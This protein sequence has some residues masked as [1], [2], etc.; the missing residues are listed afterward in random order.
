MIGQA[1]AQYKA[2]LSVDDEQDQTARAQQLAKLAEI[3]QDF[4]SR[5]IPGDAVGNA[6]K[7]FQHLVAA[8]T[9][10]SALDAIGEDG[11]YLARA[12]LALDTL[13]AAVTS[14]VAGGDVSSMAFRSIG[15]TVTVPTVSSIG[16]ALPGL[17]AGTHPHEPY[18]QFRN[19][20]GQPMRERNPRVYALLLQAQARLLQIWNGFNYLGYRDDYVPPW[21]FQYLL[22]RARYFSEH[23]KNA[24][25]D[26]LNFLSNGGN[27]ELK[28]I[29]AAQSVTLEKANVQIDTARVEQATKEVA[30]TQRWGQ[31]CRVARPKRRR[32]CS[33]IC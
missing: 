25:R 24:Q 4:N 7:P 32:G 33:G 1:E 10:N 27:E 2:R 8:F 15:Q 28:E 29:S 6:T 5:H 19:L 17:T 16:S 9:Y 30:A 18:L 26:Y 31:S 13:Q 12:K 22:D 14:T 20:D 21:R 3:A 11:E 23:A